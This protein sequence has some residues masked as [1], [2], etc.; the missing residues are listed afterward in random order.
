MEDNLS[1]TNFR[2]VQS[3]QCTVDYC[4]QIGFCFDDADASPAI[5]QAVVRSVS[6]RSNHS[7]PSHRRMLWT[8][9]AGAFD[10]PE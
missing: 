8:P 5:T 1:V 9:G 2:A 4:S 7:S 3:K 6:Q 10:E